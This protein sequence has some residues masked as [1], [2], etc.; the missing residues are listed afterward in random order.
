MNSNQKHVSGELYSS[1]AI[2]RLLVIVLMLLTFVTS[3]REYL[4]GDFNNSIIIGAFSVLLLLDFLR[5][6]K[7]K[8][9]K[10]SQVIVSFTLL[11]LLIVRV[12]AKEHF[13]D[14]FYM[15]AV[16]P[17][18]LVFLYNRSRFT[19]VIIFVVL[20]VFLSLHYY[21]QRDFNLEFY[22]SFSVY[23]LIFGGA[24][25]FFMRFMFSNMIALEKEKYELNAEIDQQKNF[26]HSF[27]HQ[28]RTPLN[29]IIGINDFFAKTELDDIQQDYLDTIAASAFTLVE[30][31]EILDKR[32]KIYIERVNDETEKIV[33][34]IYLTLNN[35][36]NFSKS[37]N[38][39]LSINL[40]ID[41]KFPS[42]VMGNPIKLKQILFIILESFRKYNSEKKL[43][44][45]IDLLAD[46]IYED[47]VHYNFQIKKIGKL[48]IAKPE[49]IKDKSQDK[50]LELLDI[51]LVR[52]LCKYINCKLYITIEED[53]SLIGL[54]GQFDRVEKQGVEEKD[55]PEK[56]KIVKNTDVDVIKSVD[57]VDAL[58]S[59]NV[60]LV[61][62]NL[63]NQKVILLALETF[64]AN[65]DVANN[66]KEALD[67]FGRT[68]YDI[69]LM[70]IQMPIM[71]GIK[72]S[73]KIREIEK[74]TN[75]YTP[76]IAVTAN[77]LQG[78][79]NTCINAGM[80]EYITKPIQIGKLK[81]L[82]NQLLQKYMDA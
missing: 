46:S 42:R 56:V 30:V 70:D 21:F 52:S 57:S 64:V 18:F 27:S 78:D 79:R 9:S 25:Y 8:K 59:A 39:N 7:T 76:I 82:M 43:V 74:S 67:I 15:A 75:S 41:E 72:A 55:K 37:Q 73:S 65:I 23:Y 26:L 28:L 32:N 4:Y 40:K 22:I 3:I 16:L 54:K 14:Y 10:I 53:F 2:I 35:F 60:L 45:E 48:H 5:L 50:L 62:D 61:E 63:I 58:K 33:Y 68:K 11:C 77:A 19:P 36:I 71:D 34:N 44:I 38:R 12:S 6:I 13:V 80:D 1:Y 66:G 81:E 17:A 51:K 31:V 49:E 47:S 24:L 69:I 20:I 29:N